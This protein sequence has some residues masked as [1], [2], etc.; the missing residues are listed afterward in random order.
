MEKQGNVTN[1]I[2]RQISMADGSTLARLL[3][4]TIIR[5][6]DLCEQMAANTITRWAELNFES[7]PWR[8]VLCA[9]HEGKIRP[10]IVMDTLLHAPRLLLLG[11]SAPLLDVT[12]WSEHKF[13]AEVYAV[14][15][16]LIKKYA[17]YMA[18]VGMLS[19]VWDI[20]G[21]F[22]ATDDILIKASRVLSSI[23]CAKIACRMKFDAVRW[24]ALCDHVRPAVVVSRIELKRSYDEALSPADR[25]ENVAASTKKKKKVSQHR[26][27]KTQ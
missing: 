14:L 13:N 24:T 15:F 1:G 2:L 17:V 3:M 12:L 27:K 18:H 25:E 6:D 10:L 8:D 22:S 26:A 21:V 7:K 16:M 20:S 19:H 23:V 11:T 4:L 5:C 9:L